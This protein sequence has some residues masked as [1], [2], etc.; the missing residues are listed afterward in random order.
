MPR[1]KGIKNG[2][3]ANICMRGHTL[4]EGR[5]ASG[6]CKQCERERNFKR[7]DKMDIA[8]NKC[9][10]KRLGIH[11]P[12]GSF[13]TPTDYNR[14]FQIQGG[15]CAND[16]CNKHQSELKQ[17][18]AVDHDH[19]T[20]IV[21]GLLCCPCNRGLGQLGDNIEAIEGILNYLKRGVS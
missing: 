2:E 6:H 1:L 14:L 21:R 9:Y 18:L 3:H 16:S 5:D 12:D 19:K 20:G 15:R 10:W 8:K 4:I 7:K 17:G 13:F 11:N